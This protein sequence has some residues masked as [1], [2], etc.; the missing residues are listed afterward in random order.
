[1][2]GKPDLSKK[3]GQPLR[4]LPHLFAGLTYLFVSLTGGESRLRGS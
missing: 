2:S 4:R 1:M 3:M